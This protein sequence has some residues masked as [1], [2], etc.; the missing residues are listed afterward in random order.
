MNKQQLDVTI[1]NKQF[2]V[3]VIGARQGFTVARRI[4]SIVLPVLGEGL[5]S[6]S[7]K[8]LING[9][10]LSTVARIL[11]EQLENQDVDDIIFGIML[12]QVYVNGVQINPDMYFAANYG[13]LIQL[14]EFI[15][16]ENFTSFLDVKSLKDKALKLMKDLGVMSGTSENK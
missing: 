2:T 8:A 3:P 13:E 4:S 9:N 15:L 6:M 5:E 11:F 1:N 7:D 12:K 14:V 10:S 16:K